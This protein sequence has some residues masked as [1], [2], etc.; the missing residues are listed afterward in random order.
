M[1]AAGEAI[2]RRPLAGSTP[3]SGVTFEAFAR[4]ERRPLVAFAWSVECSGAGSPTEATV[5]PTDG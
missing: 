3:A 5:T 2:V 4:L 1:N